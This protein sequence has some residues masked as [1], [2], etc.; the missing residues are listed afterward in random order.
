M[1]SG[2]HDRPLQRATLTILF[3][4]VVESVRLTAADEVNTALRLRKLFEHI[5]QH[6]VLPHQGTLIERLGDGMVLTFGHV[7]HAISC[8][9]ALHDAAELHGQAEQ[10]EQVIRLR[11]GVHCGQVLQ[12]SNALYGLSVSTTARICAHAP[13]GGT[14]ISESARSEVKG[15]PSS[16]FVDLGPCHLKHLDHPVRL[17]KVEEAL[18]HPATVKQHIARRMALKPTLVI[19]LEEPPHDLA[20]RA[21]AELVVDRLT[22]LLS[23]S[24]SIHVISALSARAL[25]APSISLTD[26]YRSTEARYVLRC[27]VSCSSPQQDGQLCLKASL[28]RQH[29]SEALNQ[30]Q[31]SSHLKTLTDSHHE[32]LLGVAQSMVNRLFEIELRL[33]NPRAPLASVTSQTLHLS[34]IALM[35]K[36]SHAEFERA[37]TMLA[38]LAEREPRCADFWAWRGRWHYFRVIQGWSDD[39]H[40]DHLMAKQFTQRALDQDDTCALAWTVFGAVESRLNNNAAAGAHCYRV[41]LESDPNES[42]TWLSKSMSDAIQ[43]CDG[44]ALAS[45]ETALGLSPTDPMQAYY[46]GV[47]ATAYLLAGQFKTAELLASR[48]LRGNRNSGSP[49][50]TLAIALAM[51]ERLPE[52]QET[53]Q[54]LLSVEPG[55]SLAQFRLRIHHQHSRF[56]D[57]ESALE[58]AG[59]PSE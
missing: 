1:R 46:D 29:S 12:D 7:D 39:R 57:F 11:V 9:Q 53:I 21:I 2:D 25:S 59:L 47:S 55:S 52:A 32:W 54:A 3:V 13:A 49:Y 56:A 58:S 41:A 22:R 48:S 38:A 14:L 5:A 23:R 4:D 35:H 44:D 40:S 10:S 33:A 6:V 51:Q 19:V 28:W 43:E 26:I 18:G 17:F 20:E 16:C 24:S 45:S 37:N 31:A 42:L 15:H 36:F 27:T 34:A 8:A 50:R 30:T